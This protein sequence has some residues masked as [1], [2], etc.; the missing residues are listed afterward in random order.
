MHQVVLEINVIN[1]LCISTSVI[2]DTMISAQFLKLTNDNTKMLPSCDFSVVNLISHLLWH[3][4]TFIGTYASLYG[5]VSIQ[6]SG[7][8][9]VSA[10]SRC[11]LLLVVISIL[12][13]CCQLSYSPK[14]P[15]TALAAAPRMPPHDEKGNWLVKILL[16]KIDKAKDTHAN[17]KKYIKSESLHK[18]STT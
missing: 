12:A 2:H 6:A 13:G 5:F 14:G 9:V 8:A 18:R 17:I 15:I 1:I 10:L 3:W 4:R 16:K 7:A 11:P